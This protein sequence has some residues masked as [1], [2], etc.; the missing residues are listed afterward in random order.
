MDGRVGS[1]KGFDAVNLQA[2]PKGQGRP[3]DLDMDVA[4]GEGAA[5][6]SVPL[7]QFPGGQFFQL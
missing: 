1:D 6:K 2:L 5:G 4:Q 7:R 3:G